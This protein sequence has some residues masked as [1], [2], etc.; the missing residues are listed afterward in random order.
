MTDRLTIACAQLDPVM[1]DVA[2]NAGLVRSAR[3]E[4]AAAE[5]DLLVLGELF[6]CG[7]PPEDLVLDPA[8]RAACRDAVE[9]L[10]AETADGGPAVMIGTPWEADGRLHNAVCLLKGGEVA[11]VRFK[12]NLPAYGPFEERRVFEPGELP[13]PMRLNGVAIGVPIHEDLWIDE[14]VECLEETGAEILISPNASTWT[15]GKHDMR[16]SVAVARGMESGLPLLFVNQLGGQDEH[17]FDG[18]S[19]GL[20]A[21]RSLAFQMPAFEP[22]LAVTRWEQESDGWR[23][24]EGPVAR[25]P[26]G[27]ELLWRALVLAVRDRVEKTGAPRAVIDDDGGLAAA[28][29]RLLAVDALGEGRVTSK[30]GTDAG[31]YL[32][33]ASRTELSLGA[34]DGACVPGAFNPVG[35]LWWSDLRRLAAWRNGQRPG[36]CLGPDGEAV[37]A[38]LVTSEPRLPPDMPG[39]EDLDRMLEALAEPGEGRAMSIPAV[40]RRAFMAS[41]A[42]RRQA[43]PAPV[44][45]V[46]PSGRPPRLPLVNR[47]PGSG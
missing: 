46:F 41:E 40:I 9:T 22:G 43:A 19:F 39:A 13:G 4:A 18:A 7:Y 38:G 6:V 14:V 17:V 44:F 23:C 37:P 8:F 32:V 1:G 47:F 10:A 28:V 12:V 29:V 21:D 15:L 24:V 26:E 25:L 45:T 30:G 16:L 36:G 31:A 11:S 3:A 33:A 20:G 5:A 34:G 35:G 42:A 2:H 27:D